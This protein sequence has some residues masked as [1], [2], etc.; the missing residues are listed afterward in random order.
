MPCMVSNCRFR[1]HAVSAKDA[2][3]WSR[4]LDEQYEMCPLARPRGQH[5]AIFSATHYDQTLKCDFPCLTQNIASIV[6]CDKMAH[7]S[8]TQLKTHSEMQSFQI[9]TNTKYMNTCYLVTDE[10]N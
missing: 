7:I 5:R 10:T 9:Y 8:N 6:S 4:S 1:C 3:C 2:R